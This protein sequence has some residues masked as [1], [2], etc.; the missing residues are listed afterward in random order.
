MFNRK[1]FTAVAI[2][3][4]ALNALPASAQTTVEVSTGQFDLTTTAGQRALDAELNSAVDKI[5]GVRPSSLTLRGVNSHQNCIAETKAS[6]MEQRN[7]AIARAQSESRLA[8]TGER[9]SNNAG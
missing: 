4:A 5:C 3:I 9:A 7:F 2:G 6:F 1:V 8:V